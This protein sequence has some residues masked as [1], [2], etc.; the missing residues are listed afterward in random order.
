MEVASQ[1]TKIE[2]L[3]KD[4]QELRDHLSSNA[5]GDK[6]T[7]AELTSQLKKQMALNRL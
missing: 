5:S 7:V 1:N 3:E 6:H 2:D 4:N